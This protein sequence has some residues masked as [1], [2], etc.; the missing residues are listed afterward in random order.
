MNVAQ[1]DTDSMLQGLYMDNVN[2]LVKKVRPIS[3][4]TNKIHL[5]AIGLTEATAHLSLFSVVGTFTKYLMYTTSTLAFV[6]IVVAGGMIILGSANEEM[7][8][9]A[10]G[11]IKKALIGLIIVVCCYAIVNTII[12]L[13]GSDKG[14]G[15]E[16]NSSSEQ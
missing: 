11:I 4:G 12:K 8:T 6:V 7:V 3:D 5:G 14:S 10:K 16:S 9:K 13:V 15:S 1:I 2:E